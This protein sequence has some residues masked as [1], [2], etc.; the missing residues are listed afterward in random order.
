MRSPHNTSQSTIARI[1]STI[2]P[3]SPNPRLLLDT[4]AAAEVLCVSPGYL[5]QLRTIGGGPKFLK[6]PGRGKA[7]YI[8]R[9]SGEALEAWVTAQQ[10]F[11]NTTEVDL[12]REHDSRCMTRCTEI[13]ASQAPDLS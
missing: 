8:V 5:E 12:S 13:K 10:A 11:S 7:G 2:V 9:Y 4:R 1:E 6:L 3:A